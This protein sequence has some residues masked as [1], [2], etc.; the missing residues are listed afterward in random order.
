MKRLLHRIPKTAA[1]IEAA[2]ISAKG[3]RRRIRGLDKDRAVS[4]DEGDPVGQVCLVDLDGEQVLITVTAVRGNKYQLEDGR[5]VDK[6]LVHGRVG[7]SMA[8]VFND[9][10]FPY[11]E[12]VDLPSLAEIARFYG[13]CCPLCKGRLSLK[14]NRWAC[15]S[16]HS[17]DMF[18]LVG[19][20]LL[21]VDYNPLVGQAKYLGAVYDEI[22]APEHGAVSA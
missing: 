22:L 7:T 8:F 13:N 11:D 12:D 3:G 4:L 15:S 2:R 18:D 20:V 5:L 17:G 14:R 16:K 10:D 21:G 1:A 6:K 19:Y 9:E